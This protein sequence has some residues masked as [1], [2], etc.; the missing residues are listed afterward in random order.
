MKKELRQI[1][2]I[3]AFLII[4]CVIGYFFAVNQINQFKN[5]DF[6][7]LLAS[8]NM[9]VP[10]PVD[11]TMSITLFG[12]LFSG[13]ATGIIFYLNIS[14]K[15]LTPIAPKI[16]MGIITFPFYTLAGVIG[17]IPFTIY[18]GIMLFRKNLR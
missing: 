14:K 11:I 1:L 10:E 8:H 15:W 3:C 5:P 7:A 13:I 4:G 2:F 6:I 17:V 9:P 18:N 12:W 16:F